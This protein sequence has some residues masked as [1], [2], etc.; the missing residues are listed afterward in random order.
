MSY[1]KIS[2]RLLAR[3]LEQGI[4]PTD[5][6]AEIGRTHA[7]RSQAVYGAWSWAAY[8]NDGARSVGSQYTMAECLRAPGW[9]VDLNRVR[10]F[11]E[12]TV[13][14]DPRPVRRPR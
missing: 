1:V 5:A 8:W 14:P 10:E 6:K 12:V 7:S 11:G 13:D 3:L 4:V 2:E 9:V